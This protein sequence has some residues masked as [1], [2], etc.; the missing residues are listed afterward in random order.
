MNRKFL[1][2][3]ICTVGSLLCIFVILAYISVLTTKTL[4][5]RDTIT[6]ELPISEQP[7]TEEEKLEVFEKVTTEQML[8]YLHGKYNKEFVGIDY[9]TG[10]I[11]EKEG[12]RVYPKD[13]NDR[14]DIFTIKKQEDGSYT[15][16]YPL[17]YKRQEVV[18]QIK[19]KLDTLRE[20]KGIPYYIHAELTEVDEKENTIKVKATILVDAKQVSIEAMKPMS[21]Q[22]FDGLHDIENL[23]FEAIIVNSTFV[24]DFAS[25]NE[26][27]FTTYNAKP[28]WRAGESDVG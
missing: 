21:E 28:Y 15:D 17:V 25:I 16:T 13:G 10:Q 4:Y 27:T 20:L 5:I 24:Q 1:I 18:D 12:M 8:G 3:K 7:K 6:E 26:D 14:L 19:E 22:I 11:Y 23:S 2:S 9:D